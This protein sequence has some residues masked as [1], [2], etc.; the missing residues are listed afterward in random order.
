MNI[1]NLYEGLILKNYIELCKALEID[2]KVG[3]SKILQID[4]LRRYCNFTREKQKYIIT[5]IFNSPKVERNGRQLSRKRKFFPYLE[6]LIKLSW[7]PEQEYMTYRA[8]IKRCGL[9]N[10]YHA[11]YILH[12]EVFC[13]RY[14]L[15]NDYVEDFFYEYE[16]KLNEI[17]KVA[18]TNLSKRNEIITKPVI[19]V[20]K[21]YGIVEAPEEVKNRIEELESILLDERGINSK[22]ARYYKQY[23]DINRK[24]LEDEGLKGIKYYYRAYKLDY[25]NKLTIEDVQDIFGKDFIFSLYTQEGVAELKKISINR[26]NVNLANYLC[27]RFLKLYEASLKQNNERT[28]YRREPGYLE[29]QKKLINLMFDS[30]VI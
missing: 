26:V 24:V 18:I 9:Y 22:Y 2:K 10:K 21:H 27:N 5:E 8:L 30:E 13:Q 25:M 3:K 4:K 29:T 14:N 15:R 28:N 17:L 1:N 6:V 12:K 11:E 19:M 7:I 16:K 20:K 23:S